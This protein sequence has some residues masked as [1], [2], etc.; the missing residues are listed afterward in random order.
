[1]KTKYRT[2][3][4]LDGELI[5]SVDGKP[6][7]HRDLRK[8]QHRTGVVFKTREIKQEEERNDLS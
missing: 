1:M 3:V 8:L 7:D 5:A 2:E 4:F 6:F